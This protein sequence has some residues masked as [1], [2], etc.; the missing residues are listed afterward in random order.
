MHIVLTE[1][2]LRGLENANWLLKKDR[3]QRS[4][5]GCVSSIDIGTYNTCKNGCLYCY[6]NYNNNIVMRNT[7]MHN[8]LSPLLFGEIGQDDVIKER[9]IK[10]C[11]ECQLSFFDL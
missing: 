2:V 7:Q 6:A 11:K 4:E 5:C 8:P 10:S 3:N 9:K 1:N